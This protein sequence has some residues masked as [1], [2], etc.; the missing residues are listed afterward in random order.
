MGEYEVTCVGNFTLDRITTRKG[1]TVVPGGGFNYG[2]HAARALGKRTAAVT[3]LA[4]GDRGVVASLEEIG[5]DVFASYCDRSTRLS[6]EYPSD[7][8]DER[9]LRVEDLADPIGPQ[10]VAGLRSRAF[11]V[12]PSF[13]GEVSLET[14]EMLAKSSEHL[15]VDVQGF[16]R[17]V[18]DGRV[19]YGTWPEQ[20]A[21]CS[22]ATILKVDSSEAELLTG[23]R[24]GES[25]C[26]VLHDRGAREVILTH[27]DGI[28][29]Y[30]GKRFFEAPFVARGTAGRSGRGDTCVSTYVSARLSAGPREAIV[31]AAALTSLKL[32]VPGPYRGGL[33]EVRRLIEERYGTVSV[34]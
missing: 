15:S 4:C 5:V 26:R 34:H 30:D 14:L 31:W 1:T 16:V 2:C 20:E 7:D 24:G 32:E 22:L 12:G 29:V 21:V 27:R 19:E 28:L 10:Q 8:P 11:V 9:V 13:R 33:E 17:T 3:R 6:L 18:V 25:A 23:R